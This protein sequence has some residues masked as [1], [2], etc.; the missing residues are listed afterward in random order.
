M[1]KRIMV[2]IAGAALAIPAMASATS[3]VNPDGTGFVPKGDVQSAFGWNNAG[4]QA[5]ALAVTFTGSQAASQAVSSTAANAGEQV[6]TQHASQ[7]GTMDVEQS[8]R[9][10]VSQDVT[11][12]LDNNKNHGSRD[13][14]RDGSRTGSRPGLREG[15]RE[16]TRDLLRTGVRTGSR[17]G[18]LSG[19]LLSVL[20]GL[21]RSGP[22]QFT[23]F[24]LKGYKSVPAFSATGTP[25]WG[26]PV[27]DSQ[28]LVDTAPGPY[29]WGDYSFGDPAYTAGF[30]FQD[31]ADGSYGDWNADPNENPAACLSPG[32]PH[33][34]EL[35]ISYTYGAITE[36][37]VTDGAQHDGPIDEDP[38]VYPDAVVWSD[39]VDYGDTV[40]GAVTAT[41]ATR[42]TATFTPGK[43]DWGTTSPATG[44]AQVRL[45]P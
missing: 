21:P 24:I 44:P 38:A 28:T 14:F 20:D 43:Y 33:V 25:Q 35:Q 15:S 3:T 32:D 5:N 37:G 12:L 23:G 4:L 27:Y 16:T 40:P 17:A 36:G 29:L 10:A 18:A 6:G 2:A 22:N 7:V 13:G 8:A 31:P 9:Q 26:A 19:S 34:T 39:H 1:R 30:T 11:C 41:G 42:V 45:L